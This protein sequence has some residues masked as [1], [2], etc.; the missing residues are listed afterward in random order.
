VTTSFVSKLTKC[1]RNIVERGRMDTPNIQIHDCSLSWLGTGTSI[2]SGRIRLVLL[3]E[4]STLSEMM[5][6]PHVIKHWLKIR[7]VSRM[8]LIRDITFFR[9]KMCSAVTVYS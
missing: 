3:A 7:E 4:I 5:W 9:D 8:N 6:S 2:K 1:N